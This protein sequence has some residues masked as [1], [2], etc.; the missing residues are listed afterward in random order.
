MD[1]VGALE[2]DPWART[3]SSSEPTSTVT[4]T[5]L[6]FFRFFVCLSVVCLRLFVSM[7]PFGDWYVPC[8]TRIMIFRDPSWCAIFV[9]LV[10]EE[11]GFPLFSIP[12]SFAPKIFLLDPR[13]AQ[14]FLL[15]ASFGKQPARGFDLDSGLF[16][17]AL[18]HPFCHATAFSGS[19]LIK[20]TKRR[21]G[22]CSQD[23]TLLL[24][25]AKNQQQSRN[26]PPINP[27]N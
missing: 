26:N 27:L 2:E 7:L 8:F 19:G 23:Q 24:L 16:G 18:W 21:K 9:W 14:E 4:V 13:R 22:R 5:T 15:R 10:I 12:H 25:S 11:Q 3:D 1:L 6:C 17:Q 20:T